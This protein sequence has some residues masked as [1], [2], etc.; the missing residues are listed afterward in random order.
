NGRVR[1]EGD[2]NYGNRYSVTHGQ[3]GDYGDVNSESA[4]IIAKGKAYVQ[5]LKELGVSGCRWDAAKHIGLPSE[6][7]NFWAEVTS[8]PGLWHYGEIL[9]EPASGQEG[10]IKEYV[11][12][13]S[14][15]DNKYSNGAAKDN[16][17]IYY[18]HG[19]AWA[20]NQGVDASKLVYWGESHDT[21]SND[22]W[23][24]TRDQA[25]IDRAYACIACRNGSTA[26]YLSRP[27]AVGFGNIKVGKG[28][29]AFTS[30]HISEV[31]KFRNLMVGKADWCEAAGNTFTVTRKDGGA[32]IV[33]KGSGNVNVKNGGGYCPAGTYTD[34]V[35]GGTFTVTASNI[36]GNVGASGIAVLVKEGVGPEPNPNPNPNPDP[37]PTPDPATS[38]WILG[39]LVGSA[40]WSTTPGTGVAMTKNGNTFTAN[41][42]EFV[43]AANETKC[44]FNLTDYVGATW[45]DLNMSANR[46]GAAT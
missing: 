28:S 6:G 10:L 2:I 1:W 17:G 26:L 35:S 37:V 13:M 21:Y 33:M 29:T 40:G 7:C 31:N 38:M 42:V 39:N 4:E 43:A 19:G 16:G 8:V 20:V 46:Y 11:K 23:S 22:E 15:T 9:D 3:L 44:Y 34:R 18:G 45:D 30:K 27:N 5:K 24:Q 36:S 14:V 41:G 25:T 32:V 12:Y